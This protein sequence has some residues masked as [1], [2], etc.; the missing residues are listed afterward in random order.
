MKKLISI[1]LA[2]LMLAL[3]LTSCIVTEG[4]SGGTTTTSGTTGE[5]EPPF[6][7]EYPVVEMIVEGYGTIIIELYPQYAPNTVYSFIKSV[8][9]GFYDGLIFHRVMSGFMIQGGD[10]AGTGSGNPGFSIPDEFT[11]GGFTQNTLSHTEGVI[12]M[13]NSG[14]KNS[15]GSQFFIMDAAASYLDGGYSAF[16]KVISGMDVVHAIAKAP[17][18]TI[19]IAGGIRPTVP[20]V[21]TSVTV[22]TKGNVFPE[23]VR[24]AR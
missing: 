4:R 23:P 7:G 21:I 14:T 17:G 9:E 22:D 11:T 24:I 12:S 16:G 2:I 20:I 3:S 5:T 13:A 15:S 1:T 10:P 18:T 6:T 8:Q 19:P